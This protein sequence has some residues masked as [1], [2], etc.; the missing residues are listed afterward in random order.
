MALLPPVTRPRAT[1]SGA[2]CWGVDWPTN[3]Q[4]MGRSLLGSG[5]VH[6]IS[7]LVGQPVRGWVIR[8]G[9]QQEHGPAGVFG[10]SVGK[11]T[12]GRAGPD[13]DDVIFHTRVRSALRFDAVC[14]NRSVVE[15][16]GPFS[17]AVAL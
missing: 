6:V 12:A 14:P 8:S 16:V 15:E 9:L 7:Q 13:D 1:W 5:L 3:D 2:A 4:F 17:G 10:Q 11:D